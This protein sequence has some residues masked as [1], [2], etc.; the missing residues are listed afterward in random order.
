[1]ETRTYDLSPFAPQ[2]FNRAS[3]IV[4]L[5]G[6]AGLLALSFV[7]ALVLLLRLVPST[8]LAGQAGAVVLAAVGGLFV[9]WTTSRKQRP[10]AERVVVSPAGVTFEFCGGFT[11]SWQWRSPRLKARLV[12]GSENPSFPEAMR[13]LSWETLL[14]DSFLSKDAFDAIIKSAESQGLR[15]SRSK[16]KTVRGPATFI[17]ITQ[18]DDS[19]HSRST[20]ETDSRPHKI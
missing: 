4:G 10:G 1:M 17:E 2:G 11:H 6:T 16:T 5:L 3:R 15:V 20:L 9:G 18:G 7:G 19:S 13:Y 8:N 14:R 12:D